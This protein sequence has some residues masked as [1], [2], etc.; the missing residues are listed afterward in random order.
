MFYIV[1]VFFLVYLDKGLH[2][3]RITIFKCI[4]F[5]LGGGIYHKKRDESYVAVLDAE[6]KKGL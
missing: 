2:K 6:Y 1:V 4:N 3:V 5:F